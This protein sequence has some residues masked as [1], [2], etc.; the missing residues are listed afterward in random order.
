MLSILLLSVLLLTPELLTAYLGRNDNVPGLI[1][2]SVVKQLRR[3]ELLPGSGIE[4]SD[5]L[6]FC[7]FREASAFGGA[8]H[9]LVG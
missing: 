2:K 1:T 8:G 7:V 4:C 3:S 5:N 6:A 9:H